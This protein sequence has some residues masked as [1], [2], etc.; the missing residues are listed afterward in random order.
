MMTNSMSINMNLMNN[1]SQLPMNNNNL[2]N[3]MNF[4]NMN[5][6]INNNINIM[7][8]VNKFDSANIIK[9]SHKNKLVNFADEESNKNYKIYTSPQLRL[10]TVLNDLLNLYPEINYSNN[11]LML[12]QIILSLNS[13]IE[14]LNLNNNSV[15]LI[16]N[17]QIY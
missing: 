1:M 9:F 13:T 8:Y 12:N 15:I 6:Q 16:K 3:N 11:N 14:S 17:K 4:N 5:M 7:D 10:Q 2:M